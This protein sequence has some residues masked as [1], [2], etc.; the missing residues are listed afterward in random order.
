MRLRHSLRAA[1]GLAAASA[2]S[3][4]ALAWAEPQ[5]GGQPVTKSLQGEQH[6]AGM[7]EAIRQFYQLM[8]DAGA[9]N[10]VDT[11]DV[12]ALE[13]KVRVLSHNFQAGHDLSLQQMEDHVISMTHM[14]LAIGKKDPKIFDN[15]QAFS[16]ALR[17]PN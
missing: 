15:L 14:M 4:A 13:A 17:G 10:G 12:P 3:V 8:I 16:T 2:F 6:S 1:F 9:K 7:N 5:T 11:V